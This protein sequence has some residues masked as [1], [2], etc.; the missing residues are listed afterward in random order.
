M[1]RDHLIP[2]VLIGQFAIA[3]D[4]GKSAR[5]RG[6]YASTRN[7]PSITAAVDRDC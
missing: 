3:A 5:E 4:L 7:N 2:A 6:G 1:A